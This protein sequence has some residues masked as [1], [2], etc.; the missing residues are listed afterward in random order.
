VQTVLIVDDEAGFAR[1]RLTE[2]AM[3]RNMELGLLVRGG[4]VPERVQ[5]HF[6]R[7]IERES[8][9]GSGRPSQEATA[10]GQFSWSPPR[11]PLEMPGQPSS[12][13]S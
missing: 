11:A 5:T 10:L 12:P 7:L 4:P 3:E 6:D 9:S 2:S 1:R 13:N 8:F